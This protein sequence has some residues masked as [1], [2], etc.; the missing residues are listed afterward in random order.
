[1]KQSVLKSHPFT[2]Q[3][4]EKPTATAKYLQMED[5]DDGSCVALYRDHADR[6]YA[7][8]HGIAQSHPVRLGPGA[9]FPGPGRGVQL[10]HGGNRKMPQ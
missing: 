4:L 2:A 1:M 9:F 6:W 8:E 5:E 7:E 3:Y 10:Y